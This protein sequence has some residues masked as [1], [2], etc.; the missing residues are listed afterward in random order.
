VACATPMPPVAHCRTG[1]PRGEQGRDAEATPRRARHPSLFPLSLLEVTQ[2]LPSTLACSPLATRRR[3]LPSVVALWRE[4]RRQR[5]DATLRPVHPPLPSAPARSDPSAAAPPSPFACT[6]AMPRPEHACDATTAMVS[7]EHRRAHSPFATASLRTRAETPPMASSPTPQLRPC[8]TSTTSPCSPIKRPPSLAISPPSLATTT[9]LHPLQCTARRAETQPRKHCCFA[10]ALHLAGA[11]G[12]RRSR[13][14]RVSHSPSLLC[15]LAASPLHPSSP[16]AVC[17]C[18]VHSS[19]AEESP[20][21][22][23]GRGEGADHAAVVWSRP[24]TRNS[25]Q[26]FPTPSAV[27]LRHLRHHPRPLGEP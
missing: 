25:P 1:R 26:C 16:A 9:P 18:S 21:L 27:D 15:T 8:A 24:S 7:E 23:H 14:S 12:G 13:P 3:T 22:E 17:P 5:R 20:D 6:L 4:Q 11:E 19:A 10:R 2:A